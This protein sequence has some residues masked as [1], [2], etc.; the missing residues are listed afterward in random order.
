MQIY[1]FLFY[2]WEKMKEK[3]E[4]LRNVQMVRANE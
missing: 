3:F 2:V 4:W 1:E